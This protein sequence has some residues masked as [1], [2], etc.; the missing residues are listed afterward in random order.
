MVFKSEILVFIFDCFFE[1]YED[2]FKVTY[3]SNLSNVM[4]FILLIY[5]KDIFND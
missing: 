4:N 3:K 5:S 2:F 1:N